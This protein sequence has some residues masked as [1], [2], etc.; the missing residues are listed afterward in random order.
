M[1]FSWFG[2]GTT[3]SCGPWSPVEKPTNTILRARGDEAVEEILRQPPVDL[4][5]RDRRAEAPVETRVVDV[6][7]QPV[8]V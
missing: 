4:A 3:T 5:R 7:V 1:W 6:H 2:Y 8:L